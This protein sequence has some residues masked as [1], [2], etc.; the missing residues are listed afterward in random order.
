[1]RDRAEHAYAFDYMT[2]NRDLHGQNAAVPVAAFVCTTYP[3][4]TIFIEPSRDSSDIRYARGMTTYLG[5]SGSRSNRGDGIMIIGRTV[6]HAEITDGSSSTII[7]GERPP[8][9]NGD[10]GGWYSTWGFNCTA[11]RQ[12]LGADP[13]EFVPPRGCLAADLAPGPAKLSDRCAITRFWSL[14]TGG[15]HFAFADGSAR[16]L[17]YAAHDILP[18]LATRAG[19]ETISLPM[20]KVCLLCTTTTAH[21]DS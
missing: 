2:Y 8:G 21:P 6:S 10:R 4:A 12:L 20:K 9:P 1:M 13:W 14:H 3:H 17:K 18:A 16:F 5:V 19:G 11:G 7:V 15:A